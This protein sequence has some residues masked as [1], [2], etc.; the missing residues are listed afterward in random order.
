MLM[1]PAFYERTRRL[2]RRS[3][4]RHLYPNTSIPVPSKLRLTP[5]SPMW[6]PQDFSPFLNYDAQFTNEGGRRMPE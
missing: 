2:P 1:V 5:H 4:D 6:R 3:D